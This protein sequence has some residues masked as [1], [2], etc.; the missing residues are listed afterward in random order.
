MRKTDGVDI[1]GHPTR[2]HIRLP[3]SH[4]L[5]PPT[6]PTTGCKTTLDHPATGARMERQERGVPDACRTSGK[7]ARKPNSAR[8]LHAAGRVTAMAVSCTVPSPA[9]SWITSRGSPQISSHGGSLLAVTGALGGE[10]QA[11][12]PPTRRQPRCRSMSTSLRTTTRRYR[13]CRPINGKYAHGKAP[14][15][16]RD[17][18]RAPCQQI[19]DQNRSFIPSQMKSSQKSSSPSVVLGTSLKTFPQ[20]RSAPL[21]P[22]SRSDIVHAAPG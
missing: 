9:K 7:T 5:S 12:C 2:L 15:D 13:F 6:L 19:E 16:V 20:V 11:G 18:Y 17:L 1:T 8:K 21:S 14:R 4:P 22:L 10:D 3:T